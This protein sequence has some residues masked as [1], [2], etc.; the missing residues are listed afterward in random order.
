M[1][2]AVKDGRQETRTGAPAQSGAAS[3]ALRDDLR[4]IWVSG[5]HTY[6]Y[7]D[8]DIVFIILFFR[9]L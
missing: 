3:R 7:N 1:E 5:L 9:I 8:V 6:I 2:P 4:A